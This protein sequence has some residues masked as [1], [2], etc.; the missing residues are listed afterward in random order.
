MFTPFAQQEVDPCFAGYF[1]IA[2]RISHRSTVKHFKSNPAFRP[3]PKNKNYKPR[4][5]PSRWL[6]EV[7]GR[8]QNNVR[9]HSFQ[10]PK[11]QGAIQQNKKHTIFIFS[12]Q[13]HWSV[14]FLFVFCFGCLYVCCFCFFVSFVFCFSF[15]F[16]LSTCFIQF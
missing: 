13:E 14:R 3:N 6:Q 1:F 5:T 12:P 9:G 4:F 15:L 10:S 11:P 8:G 7:D 2:P 16:V